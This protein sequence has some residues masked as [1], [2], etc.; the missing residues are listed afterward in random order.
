MRKPA[1]VTIALAAAL[2]LGGCAVEHGAAAVVDGEPI[3]VS[4]VD[5]TTRELS[6]IFTVDA[7]GVVTLLIV[8]P[9]Y[10]A[11]AS[12]L[13]VATSH[14]EARAY[15]A[16]VAE[17]AQVDIDPA[18]LSDA[19]LDILRLALSEQRMAQRPDAPE[20]FERIRDEVTA[21]DIQVSP[22]F[23]EFSL[24]GLAVVPVTPEWVLSAT[25]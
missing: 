3:A 9:S 22:R 23:G 8:T 21:L 25:P 6:Q 14:D 24:E 17:G 4:T 11:E 15:V 2:A 18:E 19:S 20:V 12:A 13:G 7:R 10:L 5:R 1:I 16:D